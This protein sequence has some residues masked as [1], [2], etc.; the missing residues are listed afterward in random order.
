MEGIAFWNGKW[1]VVTISL[2]AVL[3]S[4]LADRASARTRAQHRPPDTNHRFS[5]A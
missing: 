4:V 5:A 3:G 2:V 1:F